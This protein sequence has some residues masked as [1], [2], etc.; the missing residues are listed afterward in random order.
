[1]RGLALI[2]GQRPVRCYRFTFYKEAQRNLRWGSGEGIVL[3]PLI[4]HL[5]KTHWPSASG[6]YTGFVADPSVTGAPDAKR[7]RAGRRPLVN[8][9]TVL[10]S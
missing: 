2:S 5:A 4:E 6:E 3:P 1:M 8:A 10:L 9:H 7:R